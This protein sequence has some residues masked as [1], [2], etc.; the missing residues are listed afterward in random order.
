MDGVENA[1]LDDSNTRGTNSEVS[2]F[3]GDLWSALTLPFH[4]IWSLYM[5]VLDTPLWL[6]VTIFIT[7]LTL[8]ILLTRLYLKTKS[9]E[10]ARTF[11]SKSQKSDSR[12]GRSVT[13]GF[14]HPYCNAG[15][16]GE[17]VLW[18][19]V[20]ALH[21]RYDFVKIVIYTGDTDATPDEIIQ[22][23]KERFNIDINGQVHF[24]YLRGRAWV[25]PQRYPIL[26]LLGQSLGSIILGFEALFKFNPDV[27]I[28]TMGYA[29]TLPIF[30][31]F[32]GSKTCSYVHYPTISTDMLSKVNERQADFNNANYI[33]RN[34]I[35]SSIKIIYYK[36]F[37]WTYG[38]CG[39]CS[40]KVM[41]NSTWT[42]NHIKSIWKLEAPTLSIVYP[43][44]DT[45]R[46]E[47]LYLDE[48][49]NGKNFPRQIISVSQFR[50]EKN[51]RLQLEAFAKFHKNLSFDQSENYKLLL[52][53]SCRNDGDRGRVTMLR[54]YAEELQIASCV[55][56]FLNVSYENLLEHLAQ[57]TVGI[58]TMKD[59]HFGIGVVEFLAGG[60]VTLAY[61]SAGPK[62]DIVT[63]HN[64]ERTGFLANS[65]DSYVKA[66]NEIF[67]MTT[68]QR[69]RMC[70]N[71]RSSV[72]K[73]FSEETF[74]RKF[75]AETESLLN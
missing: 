47:Q 27:Y 10:L 60:L 16:G 65:C 55:Q 3:S 6:L 37:A 36:L 22:K 34:P 50:P 31:Y 74:E 33:A 66:L 18:C 71:A 9:N 43:P 8:F 69:Y 64:G 19:A 54:E 25:T 70:Q 51:H 24:I 32:G 59:E 41:V 68:K 12:Y 44:C 72:S 53:G 35:L 23:A 40:D 48:N 57:S 21:K 73:R 11:P 26:T 28:D 14:F 46:L 39:R 42:S 4:F 2:Y 1:T 75:I 61:D 15:G 58:H 56:F 17:R 62:M 38:C 67:S 63:D 45:R 49:E 29:F 52:V 5:L 20:R 30:K 13:I 7:G